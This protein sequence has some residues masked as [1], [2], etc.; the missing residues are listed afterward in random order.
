MKLPIF[1]TLTI[2][3]FTLPFQLLAQEQ[4]E[5][6]PY[7]LLSSYYENDFKPFKKKN[8]YTGLAF[9]LSDRKSTNTS[10]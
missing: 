9:S 5:Y 6:T 8:W 3:F 1:L 2:L 7:E 4:K 10:G